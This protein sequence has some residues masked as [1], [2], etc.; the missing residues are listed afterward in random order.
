MSCVVTH[1]NRGGLL[2]QALASLRAQ[3]HGN[4]EVIVVDDGSTDP[5]ALAAL[6]ALERPGHWFAARG[7]R[8]L[9][10]ANHYLG[11]ARNRG[12]RA[13]RGEY[14]LFMDDDNYAK[15]REV[16]T[17]IAVAARTGADVLTSCNDFLASDREAPT[18]QDV[19]IGGRYIP[20]GAST[21]LGL[22]KNGFGDANALVRKAALAALGGW[23][24]EQ[25]YGVQDWELFARAALRGFKVLVVP[26]SL[27]YYRTDARSMIHG[28]RR[29][30]LNGMY[31]RA[32]FGSPV[33][34]AAP[35]V[36]RLHRT[37]A[38]TRAALAERAREA[39]GARKLL[40][41]VHRSF[42]G[43][44]EGGGAKG[45][46]SN[47]LKNPDFRLWNRTSGLAAEWDAYGVGYRPHNATADVLRPDGPEA[48]VTD[49]AAIAVALGNIGEAG[50]AMQFAPVL[51]PRG[52]APLLL[53]GWS[54]PLGVAGA[55][56]PADYS[57]YADILF[58]DGTHHWA[59]IVPFRPDAGGWHQAHG[60]IDL[61]KAIH[62]VTVVTMLRWK[63]GTA[64]FDDVML[65]SVEDGV[66]RLKLET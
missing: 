25:G 62:S 6:A 15:P 16:E 24:E 29:V 44:A 27:Y 26:E 11:A 46:G 60:I 40:A 49:L 51:Q 1:F 7:W 31:L 30:D 54:K 35:Y 37:M 2:L 13:A 61:P 32:Y 12:A 66:C 14:V 45:P 9:R 57:L 42:C 65:S 3:T 8:V 33:G 50:G 34:H 38:E 64:L 5:A 53:Q 41:H 55:G 22:F 4:L 56:D 47:L 17:F 52:P 18:A 23:P 19:T 48:A 28:A 36:A 21:A 58:M 43:R 20:L 63:T 59:F 10:T 39:E